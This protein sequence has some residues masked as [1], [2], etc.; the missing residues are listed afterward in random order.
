MADKTIIF[1]IKLNASTAT[2]DLNQFLAASQRLAGGIAQSNDGL[3]KIGDNTKRS[4]G[5]ATKQ[6]SDLRKQFREL[7]NAQALGQN[8]D[9]SQLESLRL[10]IAQITAATKAGRAE[11]LSFERRFTALGEN[12]E[13]AYRALNARLNVARQRIKD[14]DAAGKSNTATFKQ[15]VATFGQLDK[16]IKDIDAN[17]GQYQRNVGNYQRAFAGLGRLFGAGSA[18]AVGSQIIRS[19]GQA[20]LDFDKQLIAVS[21]TT[22]LADEELADFSKKIIALGIDLKG[23]ST[24][25]LLESAEI[26]GQLGINGVADILVFSE[27]IERLRISS[28]LASEESVRAFAK[29]IELSSDTVS[30]ADRLGSVITR[31][32]NNF[33]TTEKDIVSNASEIQKGVSIYKTSAQ[34]ILAIGAATEALGNQ[35]E[36]SRSALQKVFAVLDEGVVSGK[37]LEEIL[38]LTGLSQQELTD[39]FNTDA[40]GVFIKLI[41]GLNSAGLSGDNLRGILTDLGITAKREVTV[42]GSLANN[43]NVLED[44]VSQANDEYVRNE[45]LTNESI[46]AAD[47][48]SSKLSDVKDGWN[49]LVLSIENGNGLI[50]R[51]FKVLLDG[52]TE[53]LALFGN[54]NEGGLEG[55][56]KTLQF[57]SGQIKDFANAQDQ[58]V[59]NI[60]AGVTSLDGLSNI[61]ES[62]ELITQLDETYQSLGESAGKS[63]VK[64]QD[65]LREVRDSILEENETLIDSQDKL[66]KFYNK[67]FEQ[68]IDIFDQLGGTREEATIQARNYIITLQEGIKSNE[69]FTKSVEDSA[70]GSDNY[71][72][73]SSELEAAQLGLNQATKKGKI[74]IDKLAE[75]YEKLA[76]GDNS[77]QTLSDIVGE[78]EKKLT[79]EELNDTGLIKVLDEIVSKNEEIAIA[80]ERI[81]GFRDKAERLAGLDLK[82]ISK[83]LDEA[84]GSYLDLVQATELDP[85]LIDVELELEESVKELKEYEDALRKFDEGIAKDRDKIAFGVILDEGTEEELSTYRELLNNVFEDENASIEN[86]QLAYNRIKEIDKQFLDEQVEQAKEARKLRNELINIGSQLISDVV[87]QVFDDERDQIDRNLDARLEAIQSEADARLEA[88]EG[89]ADLQEQIRQEQAVKQR[90]AEEKAAKER[91]AIRVKEAIAQASLATLTAIATGGLFSFGTL[92]PIIAAGLASVIAASFQEGGFTGKGRDNEISYS[93][94]HKNEYVTPAKVVRDPR[95]KEHIDSLERLRREHGYK[96]NYLKSRQGRKKLAKIVSLNS[97]KGYMDGGFTDGNIF[98]AIGPTQFIALTKKIEEAIISGFDKLKQDSGSNNLDP[99]VLSE[100]ITSSFESSLRKVMTEIEELRQAEEDRKSR[101]VA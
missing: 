4:V 7:S 98:T 18:L 6:I 8:V 95:S 31:L 52:T 69:N 21:K 56:F 38:K 13:G 81:E 33:A 92:A 22:D 66:D 35:S 97:G 53:I 51:A 48:I 67:S 27:T 12:G 94:Y 73:S 50:S 55:F 85:N 82:D 93:T 32:G 80:T 68:L 25:K 3:S 74:E 90:E 79:T 100:I 96:G 42:V 24:Q 45:A 99:V 77:I 76:N 37:N 59:E 83:E 72:K 91:Q 23:I 17:V 84:T 64:R 11:T 71:A 78:L 19:T 60:V 101:E 54:L 49:N 70:T 57:G 62:P 39:Q 89:N 86:R 9:V 15:Q 16:R 28:N 14:L 5:T 40:S 88:A 2:K 10:K 29:F 87:T 41:E 43:Y 44:A 75:A 65:L 20:I 58:L 46:R 61:L 30:N 26:A 36:V 34:N 1:T 63:F 47:S